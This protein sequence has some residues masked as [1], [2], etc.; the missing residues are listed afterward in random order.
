MPEP[1]LIMGFLAIGYIVYLIETFLGEVEE[2]D[3]DDIYFD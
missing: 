1:G 2:E 3:D